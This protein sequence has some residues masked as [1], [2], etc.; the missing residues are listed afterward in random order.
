MTRHS[1][2]NVSLGHFTQAEVVKLNRKNIRQRLGRDSIQNWDACCLCLATVQNPVEF[3][4]RLFC[5]SCILENILAQK[6]KIANKVKSD[7]I[8][9]GQ[10]DLKLIQIEKDEHKAE[11]DSFIKQNSIAHVTEAVEDKKVNSTFYI[12]N[13]TKAVESKEIEVLET[14][15]QKPTLYGKPVSMKKMA[16][17]SFNKEKSCPCCTKS[18]RNGLELVLAGCSHMY[19]LQCKPMISTC[20]ICQV[21]I[22]KFTKMLAVGTGF[23]SCGQN[24]SVAAT[25][26]AQLRNTARD[27]VKG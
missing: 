4:Q 25:V 22:I 26:G 1:K 3:S 8:L 7:A 13:L 12:S 20:H 19:C 21:I 23:S 15:D 11:L 14:K 17:V 10:L 6:E 2:N 24:E 27:D 16:K 9:Q 18:F 5:K